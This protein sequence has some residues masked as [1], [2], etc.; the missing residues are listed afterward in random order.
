ML[1][2]PQKKNS[3]NFLKCIPKKKK[4]PRTP[5]GLIRIRIS[6]KNCSGKNPLEE[7]P[8]RFLIK[9][10]EILRYLTGLSPNVWVENSRPP[11]RRTRKRNF[12][13]RFHRRLQLI[14]DR[15]GLKATLNEARLKLRSDTTRGGPEKT[16]TRRKYCLLVRRRP[17]SLRNWI[18]AVA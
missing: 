17:L 8:T 18:L 14:G 3:S 9:Y 2:H 5:L 6:C 4:F 13:A 16:T 10:L 15:R 1:F 7:V 12:Q 11:W